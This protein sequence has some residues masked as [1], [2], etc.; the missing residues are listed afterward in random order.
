MKTAI[1]TGGGSGIGFAIARSLA[2]E[3]FRVGLI[4]RRGAVVEAA[5]HAIAR[6]GGD[7]W[8]GAVDVRDE[9]AVTVFVE[10]AVAQYGKI[11]LLVNNAGVFQM[12]PFEETTLELWDETIDINLKGAF[13]CAKAVW[14]HIEGGQ[15]INIS[16][17]AGL[18]AFPGNAAYCASKFGLN[19]LSE[20]LALEGEKRN[21]RVHL[22]CPGNTQTPTWGDQAPAEVQARMMPPEA[23]AEVVRWLAVSPPEVTFDKVVVNPTRDP[24]R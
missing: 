5:A 6:A 1:I 18:R 22:V 9:V 23:V 24:W 7:S 10:S 20:V 4:G 15:I 12:R 17:V 14:P 21:I 16:S 8:W 13:I 11:N 19:G 3:Q 2:G